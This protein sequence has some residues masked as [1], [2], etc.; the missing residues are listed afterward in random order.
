MGDR[1]TTIITHR[2]YQNPP[3]RRFTAL[4]AAALCFALLI[5]SGLGAGRPTAARADGGNSRQPVTLRFRFWGDIKEIAI[6]QHTVDEFEAAHPGVHVHMERIS[7]NGDE[8]VQ[9]LLLEKASNLLPDVIFI[10]D[11]YAGLR[12]RGVLADLKPLVDSDPSVNLSQYYP[13]D[14]T[15]FSEKGQLY[16]LPR[17]IA[18]MG[19]IYYNK[20]LFDQA[21]IP[22]PD[23]SWRW[24]YTPHPERGDKDFLT[25]CK[26]LTQTNPDGTTKVFGYGAF[27]STVTWQNFMYCT[28]DDVVDNDFYPT[29]MTMS[30]PG[31]VKALQLYQDMMYK[32]N[33]APAS[34]DLQTSGLGAVGGH[35]LFA[36]GRMA[37][38]CCGIWEVPLFRSQITDFDWDI[39]A[40][41]TG[42][43]GK[44]GVETGWSG[45]GI[46]STTRHK[47]LAWELV[48]YLGGPVGLS[49]LAKGGLAQP[50]IAKLAN[51]PLWLDNA[52]PHNRKLTIEEVP[53]IHYAVLNSVWDQINTQVITPKLQLMYD[54]TINAQQAVN[55]IQPAAQSIL[56][57][58]NHPT[59]HP[60][61]NWGWAV[62]AMIALMLLLVGW[63]WQGA[64]K[65]LAGGMRLGS[66]AEA[67]AGYGFISLWLVGAV[68]FLLAPMLVSLVLSFSQ[69]DLISPAKWLGI[70]NYA[71]MM[72]DPLFW[73]SLFVTIVYTVVSVPLGVVGSLGL[74]LLLNAKIKGQPIFRTLFYMPSIVSA[75]AAS[76]IWLRI[77]DPES[78][79]LNSAIHGLHLTGL[80]HLLHLTDP[81]KNYV[82]WLGNEHTANGSIIVMSLWAIGGGMVIYLAGLQGIP[83]SYY[84]AADIDGASVWQKFRN[85]TLPLLTPTIFFTIIMG[86]IGSFQV[87]TQGYIMTSGGPNNATTYYVLYLYQ[88]AFNYLKIGYASAL[89]W[90]L[91]FIILG[92]TLVQMRMSRW[93]H[94]EGADA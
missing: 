53:H 54:N 43:T 9:K 17:D 63:V 2:R 87:F 56:D 47:E 31:V 22:Y 4:A 49:N 38:Y 62:V 44:L 64:R 66:T 94:Y 80:M 18:P 7:T 73:K 70:A 84:E 39:A 34:A 74:A 91:F 19:L 83:Q 3:S 10:A 6:I 69:W 28:G 20:K 46:G 40:F 25:V 93:V 57:E 41:P 85:V 78:G 45:Y 16:A 59:Y 71:A 82:N 88:N 55:L 68:V 15:P 1:K 33:V 48:K 23:G 77:F 24:D 75:V 32:Y 5:A 27:S 52:A 60:P 35:D 92:I 65:D 42:P 86:I 50:A 51:S 67:R 61:L 30:T 81:G 14:I 58:Y 21:H 72:K 79:I 90:V 29:K 13:E 26:K 8:Y 36:T 37:M 89:A 12:G 76:L 11:N